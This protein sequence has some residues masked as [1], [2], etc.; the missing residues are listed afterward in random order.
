MEVIF[1]HRLFGAGDFP[2]GAG[3]WYIIRMSNGGRPQGAGPITRRAANCCLVLL[4]IPAA[5][6][7]YF[8]YTVWHADQV[9]SERQQDT[10][11]S[12]LRRAHEQADDTSH[13]L[14]A[15]GS[16]ADADT[17][18]GVIWRHS[19]TPLI[20]YD[21][22]HHRFTATARRADFYD[23]EGVIL[24]SGS[25]Q[26]ARCLRFTFTRGSDSDWTSTVAVRD[27]EE[28][29]PGTQIGTWAG[30][31]RS[32]IAEMSTMELTPTGVQRALDPTG[33]L[34][35]FDVRTVERRGR[36]ATVTVLIQDMYGAK[37]DAPAKQCYRFVRD[38]GGEY[39]D[40]VTSVPL[41]ACP[42]AA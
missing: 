32:R 1:R 8:W 16:G 10:L 35:H 41:S 28:C 3:G 7:A 21:P 17:L 4:M 24:G 13:A 20:S 6:V 31:A 12:I 25:V 27:Y 30:T 14:T 38:L 19:E 11:N 9:N 40:D 5:L 42:R 18:T 39:G 23:S 22:A 29:L 37:A 33:K 15:S 2:A 26:I 36:T 34:G